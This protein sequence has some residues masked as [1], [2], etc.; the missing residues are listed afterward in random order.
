MARREEHPGDPRPPYSIRLGQDE[1]LKI[2]AAAARQRV[3]LST[4]I[5]AAALQAAQK[6]LA[7][8]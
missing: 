5:R 4:Y 3:T 8:G 1:R 6:D 2:S 7:R